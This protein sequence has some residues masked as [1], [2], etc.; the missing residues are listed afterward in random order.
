M[1]SIL[2][3]A[4]SLL[5]QT[6]PAPTRVAYAPWNARAPGPVVRDDVWD[7]TMDAAIWGEAALDV[8]AAARKAIEWAD[9][10]TLAACVA[11]FGDHV[12]RLVFERRVQVLTTPEPE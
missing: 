4:A 9:G 6:Q 10:K 5:A 1:R 12:G 7:A 8:D 3:P 11:R 2:G